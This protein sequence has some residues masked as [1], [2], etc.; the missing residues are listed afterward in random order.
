MHSIKPLLHVVPSGRLPRLLL[1][2]GCG[3]AMAMG[4]QASA[5]TLPAG[6]IEVPPTQVGD[7]QSI[8][9]DTTVN[10]SAGGTVG[11]SFTA[12]SAD[13]ADT[14]VVVNIDG[15]EIG[16]GLVAN[17]GSVVNLFDGEAGSILV[18]NG[19][20]LNQ[21]GGASSYV[22]VSSGGVYNLSGGSPG[23]IQM[24][25]GSQVRVSGGSIGDTH[26][27][28]AMT[29]LGGEFRV[30]GVPVT[31]G[32][33]SV[34]DG[35]IFSGTLE[36]GGV[37]AHQGST[38]AT[39][40]VAETSTPPLDLTPIV[41]DAPGATLSGL[42]PG[43]SLI[44]QQGGILNSEVYGFAAIGAEMEVHGGVAH[45]SYQLIDSQMTVTGGQVGSIE[46][47][48]GSTLNITGGTVGSG[49]VS[50][51]AW[52]NSVVNISG[53][54]LG[55]RFL[56][57][58]S[59]TVN[60]SGGTF[61][62]GFRNSEGQVSIFGGE[63]RRNG[64]IVPQGAVS[65]N[66][67][68]VLT[69]TLA[70][71][72]AFIFWGQLFGDRLNDVNL[73]P[74]AVPEVDLTT[75]QVDSAA[76]PNSLRPGQTMNLLPG[77]VLG[78]DFSTVDATLHMSGGEA[79]RIE[80]VGSNLQ[81]SGGSINRL[82]SV[83]AN[84]IT[85]SGASV[86]RLEA[87]GESHVT[88]SSGTIGFGSAVYQGSTLSV[89]GGTVGGFFDAEAG[90]VVNI[91]GGIIG[92][93]FDALEGSEVNLSGGEFSKVGAGSQSNLN[94]S[95][96]AFDRVIANSRSE[97]NISGGAIEVF[98]AGSYS[99]V[100]I[101]GGEFGTD[102]DANAAS[103]LNF[104]GTDF[105]LDGAP[106][107]GLSLGGTVEVTDRNK[108]LSGILLDGS[109]FSL[110]LNLTGA[111]D[112]PFVSHRAVLKVA[113]LRP[114]TLPGDYNSDGVVN[115]ADYSVWRNHLGE[116]AGTLANDP[117]PTAVGAAQYAT[118]RANFAA[119]AN[120]LRWRERSP[121]PEP[122]AGILLLI[123]AFGLAWMQRTA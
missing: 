105:A 42:R 18:N 49:N 25:P 19:A 30:N 47:R 64:S 88:M 72:S 28:S 85:I 83:A 22:G 45:N 66:V 53:G 69:G 90:S 89:S 13:G 41:V 95:G 96:G 121:V 73:V 82:D 16:N 79:S 59:S 24:Q 78:S 43:Q 15:G 5:Q 37:F 3:L 106:I 87:H 35:D 91:S 51:A 1:Y 38:Q 65:V 2:T 122:A 116:P 61:A 33:V 98:D 108:T 113:L 111:A 40:T 75:M 10:I 107:A 4:V 54:H 68:D 11:T 31:A 119:T 52:E 74:A 109:P 6:V 21:M 29:F 110:P 26:L 58:Q 81:L 70:D 71:G 93:E 14:N 44:V 114:V 12:G 60:L 63:F 56:A 76:A 7:T 102:F 99:V 101:S 86:G 92:D 104:F 17:G 123:G 36:D 115:M 118:W 50:M 9:S 120:L 27:T 8:G 57:R 23:T 39:F 117:N 46:P 103:Q 55:S 62:S 67:G 48:V 77:G 112:D 20:V 32:P 84:N 80:A 100:N 34:G 97:V 94:I